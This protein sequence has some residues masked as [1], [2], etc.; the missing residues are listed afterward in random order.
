MPS[1]NPL[2]EKRPESCIAHEFLLLRL[3]VKLHVTI[4]WDTDDTT[5]H[6]PPDVLQ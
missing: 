2:L 6:R 5:V 4:E 3:L 1:E